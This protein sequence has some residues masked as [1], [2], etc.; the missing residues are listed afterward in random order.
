MYYGDASQISETGYVPYAWQFPEE[1]VVIPAA[2]G[3]S[4]NC[5]GLLSR[6]NELVFE[7]TQNTINAAFVVAFLDAFS[8]TLTRPTVVVLDNASVHTA[9]KVK[10]R[11]AIWQNR[12]LFIFYLP[13][14]SPNLNIIE[15]M[16]KELKGRWLK[17]EDYASTDM[18][19]YATKLAL[20]AVGAELCIQ[21]NAFN[22]NST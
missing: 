3:A 13:P 22:Y 9:K 4:L 2:R 6:K 1:E 7:T 16:W 17:P 10:E 8:S 21:F 12:G 15:R 20:Q 19:F 11:L 14:Y 18:L 5:F